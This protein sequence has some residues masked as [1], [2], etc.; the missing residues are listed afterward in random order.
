MKKNPHARIIIGLT[1]KEGLGAGNRKNLPDECAEWP[2]YE[3]GYET[4]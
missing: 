1:Y 3:K 4:R 2:E